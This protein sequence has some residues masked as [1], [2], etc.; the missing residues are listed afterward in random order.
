MSNKKKKGKATMVNIFAQYPVNGEELFQRR[1]LSLD[2]K[3]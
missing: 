1:L 3:V 2:D